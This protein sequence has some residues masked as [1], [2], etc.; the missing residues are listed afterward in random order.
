MPVTDLAGRTAFVTGGASGIGLGIAHA[1]ARRG[2]KVVIADL[3]A[4]HI[5]TALERFREFGLGNLVTAVELDVTDRAAFAA[6]AARMEAERGGIDVLVNNAGVGL[7]GPLAKATH[8]DWDFGMG[9]N[10]GGVVNGLQAFLPQMIAH[11]RGGH[12]VNTASLAA[13]TRMPGHFVIYAASKAAVLNLTENIRADLGAQGIGVTA[14]CPG[15]VKSNIHQAAQNR[16]AHLREGS[17]FAESEAALGR[18]QIEDHWMEPED[19]GEMV[20]DAILADQL[21]V[22][23][24]DVFRAQMEEKCRLLLEAVPGA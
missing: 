10:F 12:V 3:R 4:D 6:M 15:W 17:G 8:A 14:L 9:V 2:C 16:P 22:I 18:R 13:T 24:H 7:E 23:T 1:L 19:V 21:Y 20:A 11:G 5:T